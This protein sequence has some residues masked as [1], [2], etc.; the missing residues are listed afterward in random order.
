M[1]GITHHYIGVCCVEYN[2]LLNKIKLDACQVE[3]VYPHIWTQ[4]NV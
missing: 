3:G 4:L 1:V 2:L